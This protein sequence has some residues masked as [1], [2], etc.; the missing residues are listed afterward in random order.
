MS[1]KEANKKPAPSVVPAKNETALRE[2]A[3]LNFWAEND[4]FN[5]SVAKPAGAEPKGDYVFYDGPPFA[6]GL[7]HVGNLL[8]SVIKDVV[9]RYWTMKGYRVERRWGWDCHGLPIEN[10]I[11][12]EKGLK[13]KKAINELGIDV[14]NEACR[15]AVLRFSEEWK[16][17][18][19]RLGRWVEYDGAY[20]TMDNSYMESVWWFVAEMHK[21]GLLYEGR[22]VLLYCPHCETPL[23]KAE[24][25][26]DNS[27]KDV[28]EES[29][30]VK[31]K[32]KTEGSNL[33][34][35]TYALAWTTTPWTLPGNVALA[36]DREIEY[37]LLK[38]DADHLLV[39]KERAAAVCPDGEM[40]QTLTGQDLIG[41]DY[42]PLYQIEKVEA[43]AAT[44]AFTILPAEFV[45]TEDGTGIVH[46]AVMYGEDDF[47]LGK[48]NN[49][50]LV[51]L[52][53]S[54]G[55]FTSDGPEFVV[56]QYFKKAEKTIKSDLAERDLILRCEQHTHSYPHC[57]RCGAA[58]LYNALV[59]WFIDIQKVKPELLKTNE[60]INWYPDHLKHGRYQHILEN[61][62]DWT[63]SRNRFWATPLPI[64]RNLK[65]GDL[66]VIG[67]VADL[68]SK[69]KR[70]G[71][72]Y[73]VMRHAEAKSN[74]TGAISALLDKTNTLTEK[75]EEQCLAV[76]QKLKAE[77]I[78][79]VIHSGLIRT[80]QTAERLAD[81]LGLPAEAVRLD[82]R[83]TE[84]QAGEALE[85][86]R[87][88]DYE[89]QF[90]TYEERFTKAL[91]RGENR[92]DV[93]K[94][95]GRFL[96][97]LEDEYQDKNI[98]IISHSGA[99]FAL[100]RVAEGA[101]LKRSAACHE[102][103]L[104]TGEFSIANAEVRE[105]DFVPLP[106]NADYALDLHRPYID[107]ITLLAEDGTELERV[108][109]VIDVWAES[110]S[111]P[112]A[113]RNYPHSHREE[114][115]RA[116]PADFIAEY[117][118][119]TRTWF[120]YM[121]TVS[122]L[123]F[124]QSSFKNVVATG[125]VL[126]DDGTKMSKSKLNFTDPLKSLNDYGADAFR[127]YLMSSVVMQAEDMSFRDSELKE[128]HN[129]VLNILWN[130]FKFYD[131]YQ[132]ESQ[133]GVD[134]GQSPHVLD[135][136]IL[137]RLN[138]LTVEVTERMD[139]YDL[140][141]A[142]RPLRDF[143]EDFSTWYVRRS[144][145]RFKGGDEAD[146]Q[147]ALA[148][149]RQVLLTLAK[150]LAPTM[151][152]V[153]ESLHQGIKG[154]EESVHLSAWPEAGSVDEKLLTE[155]SAVRAVVSRGLEARSSAGLKVRQPL[156]ALYVAEGS[157]ALAEAY[158]SIVKD[159]LNV[160]AVKAES[161]LGEVVRLDTEL[162]DDLL[163]EG[164]V[165]DFI[166]AVQDLRKKAGLAPQDRVNLTVMAEPD[167]QRILEQFRDMVVTTVGAGEFVFTELEA[168]QPIASR[169]HAFAVKI[170]KL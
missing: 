128:V 77:K 142:T 97:E 102:A 36:V 47:E 50:P 152:F 141:R 55:H 28:S 34:Q 21:K 170:E 129:R 166:R 86:K 49:L 104:T 10:M 7:P 163:A 95:V 43:A 57:Y 66:T 91:E 106:H 65:T 61:A 84:L 85:G 44:A 122:V 99:I 160:K 3:I 143:V 15:A 69:T 41:L 12:K 161:G 158:I 63:I 111:M 6:T 51:P 155:M 38:T 154:E 32:L 8:S 123:L 101:D 25:A 73:L 68:K 1:E 100:E 125:N 45:N 31:F 59:S 48:Q 169:G 37:V 9:G 19:T 87:W 165:R 27:Y 146:K 147:F 110:G 79:L 150:L 162:T 11:E 159:E 62:P 70:S 140:S 46:T 13:S 39:A 54:A 107:A 167:G 131:L 132:G 81:A 88:S 16:K 118:A 124:G 60:A 89:A 67:S 108:P 78:D 115:A 168:G 2:E 148:T 135:R 105:L 113:A 35:D 119:Q 29:V 40:E 138:S 93:Q 112:F 30:Y 103:Y 149:T 134:A 52:L 92:L 156:A 72:R 71:N 151:P 116:F 4:I 133:E 23:S 120:Y 126:A 145:D 53:D 153:A 127:Y 17:Y 42:E 144:R 22:R 109:E 121:H 33:P 18:V 20:R 137:T 80:R 90:D 76:A 64:W 117:I 136:W 82:E 98:L 83:V 24:I 130:T 96:Y 58:L 5:K 56:G 164:I 157:P 75:G 74:L 14:F 94:R 139:A 114:F 26:M